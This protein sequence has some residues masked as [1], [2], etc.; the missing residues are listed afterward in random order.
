MRQ[1]LGVL[2]ADEAG[3]HGSG[4]EGRGDLDALGQEVV[5]LAGDHAAHPVALVTQDLGGHR[6]V[7]QG[8]D[9]V[10]HERA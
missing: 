5:E 7:G 8:R 6:V 4:E 2:L 9:G 1:E 10:G 3:G